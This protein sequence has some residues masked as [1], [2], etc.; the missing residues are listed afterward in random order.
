MRSLRPSRASR[1]LAVTGLVLLAS[2][3]GANPF[4]FDVLERERQAL[5]E[6]RQQ[7]ASTG[8]DSYEFT[9][10]VRCMCGPLQM[11]VRVVDGAVVSRVWLRDGQPVP[12]DEL[13]GLD[14]VEELFAYLERA[15]DREPAEIEV[16]YDARG[17]PTHAFI[18]WTKAA[19]D[20]ESGFGVEGFTVIPG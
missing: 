4:D 20:E 12:A 9:V 19:I 11:R 8:I 6:A 17:I 18:D 15:L 5:A 3:C 14:T 16:D 2:A 10:N 1:W 7:W 13:T